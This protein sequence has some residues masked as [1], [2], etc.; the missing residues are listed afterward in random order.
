M[1]PDDEFSDVEGEADTLA[2]LVL[3][4]KGDFPKV[5]EKF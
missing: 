2:G 3:E 5:H 4:M 1:S